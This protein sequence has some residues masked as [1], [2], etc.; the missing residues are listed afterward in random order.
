[1]FL[2][3]RESWPFP[4]HGPEHHA[5]VPAALLIAYSN[6]HG[7]PDLPE[8][9][10]AVETGAGLAGGSCAFWGA[11]SAVLGIGVAFSTILEATPT[12]GH[13]RCT[14]QGAVAQILARIAACDAP[15]CCRRESLL[16]LSMACELSG[17]V[18]PH[19]VTTTE[20]MRCDQMWAN[21]ECIGRDCPWAPQA[22]GD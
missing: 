14:V 11:C 18:L 7:Y 21:D 13:E 17:E 9:W 6:L 15:R 5:L 22:R 19:R 20:E 12:R 4:V 2:E 16:A 1:V 8:I 3:M 10:E